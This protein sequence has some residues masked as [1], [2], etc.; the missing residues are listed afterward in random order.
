MHHLGLSGIWVALLAA[1]ERSARMTV[2]GGWVLLIGVIVGVGAICC[3]TNRAQLD[4]LFKRW[5]PALAA[6]L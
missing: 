4:A 6:W 5:R 2:V 1:F 3:K